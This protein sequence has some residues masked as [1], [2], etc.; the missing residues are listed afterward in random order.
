MRYIAKNRTI[1]LAVIATITL[2]LAGCDRFG[3]HKG[4]N[5]P[6]NPEEQ[7]P[8]GST[9]IPPKQPEDPFCPDRFSNIIMLGSCVHIENSSVFISR[10]GLVQYLQAHIDTN[11]LANNK[12]CW[13]V[14]WIKLEHLK[15][16]NIKI[17]LFPV[18]TTTKDGSKLYGSYISAGPSYEF[19][20][21]WSKETI[22]AGPKPTASTIIHEVAHHVFSNKDNEHKTANNSEKSA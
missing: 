8:T 21:G 19:D 16:K 17:N 14:Y 18:T 2:L 12:K 9:L 3:S 15:D 5:E 6:R 4:S 13:T 10:D 11:A 7:P 22:R 20:Y 1:L